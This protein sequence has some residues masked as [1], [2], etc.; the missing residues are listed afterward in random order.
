[1]P[2]IKNLVP[3]LVVNDAKAAAA[4]YVS[5]LGAVEVMRMPAEDGRLLHVELK[6]GTA[7]LYL[8]DDFPEYFEGKSRTPQTLGGT[9]VSLHLL[10]AN[11]DESV[12]LAAAGGA[13]VTMPPMDAFWGDRFA[14]VR[15][16]F[17]H[18]WSFTHPLA[19]DQAAAA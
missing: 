15:D 13:T 10:V 2:E 7:T 8:A 14:K 16:P 3:Y 5:A 4:F 18:E 17:G 11:C 19:K 9:P 12:A 6:L 1:M